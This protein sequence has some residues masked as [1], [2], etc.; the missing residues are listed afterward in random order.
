MP[1]HLPTPHIS[2]SLEPFWAHPLLLLAPALLILMF[3]SSVWRAGRAL[4]LLSLAGIAGYGM[5]ALYRAVNSAMERQPNSSWVVMPAVDSHQRETAF[6]VLPVHGPNYGLIAVLLVMAVIVL[7]IWGMTRA[8][9]YSLA[10]ALN[11]LWIFVAHPV[12]NRDRQDAYEFPDVTIGTVIGEAEPGLPDAAK[13]AGKKV[14]IQGK[15]RFLNMG[16]IGPIGSGKTFMTMKPMIYQDLEAL[17]R[18]VMGNVVWISPQPEP[19]IEAYAEKLGLTVRRIHIIDGQTGEGK[20]TNIRFNPLAGNDI[21]AIINNVNVV[22]NEQTGDRAKGE[23]FFDIMAAQVTTDSLQLYKFLHGFDNDGNPVEIDIIGWY[24]RYLVQMDELFLEASRVQAV[25]AL[26]SNGTL[27]QP[28]VDQRSEWIRNVVWPRLTEPQRVML[29]RAAASIINEFGGS[30]TGKNAEAYKNIIRGLRGKVRVL[31]SSQYVQELLGTEVAA[32]VGRP[33]FDFE[34]WIDPPEWS[35]PQTGDLEAWKQAAPHGRRG[36]LLSVITGQTETGKLVGRMVLVFLQQAVLNRPG[37]DNDKPPV[38]TYVDEYPSYATRSINEIR[39][40]GRKHCHSM[41]M[42]HQSRG[43][44]DDVARNYRRTLE[45]STRHWIYLSN[46]AYEDAEDVS[47]MCGKVKRIRTSRSTRQIRLGGLGRDD[48]Q[49]LVT[50]SESEELVPRFS[51]DFIRFGL[52]E[53]EVIYIG[54]KNRRGQ[55]P[56][57]MRIPEPRENRALVNKI[58]RG[59]VK[60]PVQIR[61]RRPV[62]VYPKS[63][64]VARMKWPLLT[65]GNVTLYGYR[66]GLS[67]GRDVYAPGKTRVTDT[68]TVDIDPPGLTSG[69]E[70][71]PSNSADEHDFHV[72]EAAESDESL[73]DRFAGSTPR[74]SRAEIRIQTQSQES[75]TQPEETEQATRAPARNTQTLRPRLALRTDPERA[76][77]KSAET[78]RSINRA[79]S[80]RDQEQVTRQPLRRSK[81]VIETSGVKH[82]EIDPN[83]CCPLDGE[84]MQL[85][86]SGNRKVWVCTTCGHRIRST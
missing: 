2:L 72:S 68:W 36:E 82:G 81:S 46:L 79:S 21:D 80:W 38:Y 43:Q 26:E 41:V 9:G 56:V 64:T 11:R 31:I 71:I 53:N 23:A 60:K 20:T 16:I 10:Y 42:A 75:N 66:W 7:L 25:A 6:P 39:T 59:P 47:K 22:L 77:V 54:V 34:S 58:G 44:M 24:D 70:D 50:K 48:G 51:S 62:S 85:H 69:L 76:T 18:G 33:N 29:R 8:S 49:P 15:D 40:Q 32:S 19:S 14:V 65:L 63:D 5:Y 3:A 57:R 17:A 12:A 78:T 1:N 67:L 37:K 83:T 55:K 35:R 27:D 13:G 4:F 45:G 84:P 73:R 74:E 30:L 52:T 86:I 61:R 28:L